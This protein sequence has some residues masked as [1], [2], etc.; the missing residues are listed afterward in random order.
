MRKPDGC[1]KASTPPDSKVPNKQGGGSE[2]NPTYTTPTEKMP[3][4]MR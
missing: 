1:E 3:S 2:Q 4:R